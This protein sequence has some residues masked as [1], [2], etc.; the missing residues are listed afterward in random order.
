MVIEAAYGDT[1]GIYCCEAHAEL[2]AQEQGMGIAGFSEIED[3]EEDAICEYPSCSYPLSL[4][5]GRG[6]RSEE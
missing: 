6:H 1:G 5:S 4:L 2:H 3:V